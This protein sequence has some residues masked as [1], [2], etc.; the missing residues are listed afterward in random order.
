MHLYCL[1][2]NREYI[3]DLLHL[4]QK[5]HLLTKKLQIVMAE[6]FLLVS[7]AILAGINDVC[8]ARPHDSAQNCFMR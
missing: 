4:I 3:K 5:L 8:K 6:Q 2:A 1:A 7:R